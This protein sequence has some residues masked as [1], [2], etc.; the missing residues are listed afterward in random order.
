MHPRHAAAIA[1]AISDHRFFSPQVLTQ[2]GGETSPL[3]PTLP[4]SAC[5]G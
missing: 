5:G 1:F 2:Y 4:E 3:P